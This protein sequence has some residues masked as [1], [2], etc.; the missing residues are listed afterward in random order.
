MAKVRAALDQSDDFKALTHLARCVARD[1]ASK[2]VSSTAVELGVDPDHR[3][4]PGVLAANRRLGAAAGGD[5]GVPDARRAPPRRS[6]RRVTSA[7]PLD[8]GQV[9]ALKQ[10]LRQRV[11]RDVNA[12]ALVDPAVL[13][14]WSSGSARR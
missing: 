9:A 7:H 5:P 8:D 10:S 12:R 11:G 14:G 2:A 1:A 13:A 6:L 4:P 3:A